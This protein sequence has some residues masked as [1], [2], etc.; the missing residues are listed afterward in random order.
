MSDDTPSVAGLPLEPSGPPEWYVLPPG[1]AYV[2][3]FAFPDAGTVGVS[4]LRGLAT[5]RLFVEIQHGERGEHFL[6]IPLDL[7]PTL[8]SFGEIAAAGQP[9]GHLRPRTSSPREMAEGAAARRLLPS[10]TDTP[11][12]MRAWAAARG[13]ELEAGR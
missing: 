10:W 3:D 11:E 2:D 5:G 7:E 12:E 4:L 8:R 13:V 1:F 9:D 6:R